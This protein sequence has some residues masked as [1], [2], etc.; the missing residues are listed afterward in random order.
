M[1]ILIVS[2][3]PRGKKSTTKKLLKYTQYRLSTRYPDAVYTH[4]ELS[5]EQ[6]IF[7]SEDF[8]QSL[9]RSVEAFHKDNMNA[10]YGILRTNQYQQEVTAAD[11]IIVAYPIWNW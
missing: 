9:I 10:S 6:P 11:I 2:Y 7:Y 8:V 1:K 3:L 5:H 4:H